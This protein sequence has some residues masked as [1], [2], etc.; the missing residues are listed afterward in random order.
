MFIWCLSV[1]G[2]VGGEGG[3]WDHM[4]Y[5]HSLTVLMDS[6]HKHAVIV[7]LFSF[8][9]LNP[10]R[11]ITTRLKKRTHCA[12]NKH[13]SSARPRPPHAAICFDQEKELPRLRGDTL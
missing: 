8:A 1:A 13:D 9:A 4:G 6:A 3:G 12:A 11:T 2:S 5:D 7:F 10:P